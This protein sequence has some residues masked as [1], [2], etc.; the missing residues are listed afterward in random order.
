MNVSHCLSSH[1]CDFSL[2]DHTV[3]TRVEPTRQQRAL[4]K[5][6]PL[7]NSRRV[8]LVCPS[9]MF[10]IAYF[11]EV[12][13]HRSP[14]TILACSRSLKMLWMSVTLINNSRWY[15]T[16]SI[17]M[18]LFPLMTSSQ[19]WSSSGHRHRVSINAPPPSEGSVSTLHLIVRGQY[20]C[21]T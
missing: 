19:F 9:L 15:V 3:P 8:T 5:D 6:P 4:S 7:L 21:S 13:A 14:Q 11:R 18:V 16:L 1:G 2:A 20:Q 12:L 17:L 10:G